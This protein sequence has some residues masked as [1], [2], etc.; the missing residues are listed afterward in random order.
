MISIEDV[1]AL[2]RQLANAE[3]SDIA[4]TAGMT[5]AQDTM[6]L[7]KQRV[8]QT[9][10][11]SKGKKFPGYSDAK[12]PLFFYNGRSR[13]GSDVA[14]KR[15]KS[16]VKPNT[17]ASYKDWR[18]ANNLQVDHKDFTFTGRT[19]NSVRILKT[20][21]RKAKVI[22]AIG[23]STESETLEK[24]SKKNGNILAWSKSERNTAQD[25]FRELLIEGIN[26]R[27]S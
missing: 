9:G 7:A 10:I 14:N 24:I 27:L 2:F 16:Q 8:Q 5:S 21:E 23:S 22:I 18:I 13:T 19:L 4:R 20:E 1:P 17:M 11:D 15:L 25:I 3:L 6:T 26:N 12:V